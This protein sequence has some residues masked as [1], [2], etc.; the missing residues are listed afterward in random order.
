MRGEE[1]EQETGDKGQGTGETTHHIPHTTYLIPHNTQLI[2]HTRHSD[3]KSARA[4]T[5]YH[6]HPTPHTTYHTPHTT[7]SL[8]KLCDAITIN[9]YVEHQ[10][11]LDLLTLRRS[12]IE[13]AR[14]KSTSGGS[15][16]GF[17]T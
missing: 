9:G 15:I 16:S 1:C 8:Y 6:T 3:Y 7:H 11:C 5:T 2:S 17:V 4:T 13:K 10:M 12:F 14:D